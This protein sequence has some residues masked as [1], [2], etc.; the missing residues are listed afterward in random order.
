VWLKLRRE[1]ERKPGGRRED[2]ALGNWKSGRME[3]EEKSGGRESGELEKRQERPVEMDGSNF[4]LLVRRL[5]I[6][7][8]NFFML[9]WHNNGAAKEACFHIKKHQKFPNPVNRNRK[10]GS[11]VSLPQNHGHPRNHDSA[12]TMQKRRDQL[13]TFPADTALSPGSTCI[14]GH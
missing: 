1:W 3:E 2:L 9:T 7:R 8:P 5:R 10:A 12:K 11:P 4:C 13:K 6:E 14:E